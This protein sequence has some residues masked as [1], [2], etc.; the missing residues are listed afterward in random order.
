MVTLKGDR[1]PAITRFGDNSLFP[2]FGLPGTLRDQSVWFRSPC[3]SVDVS[4]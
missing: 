4:S 2:L 3:P 1:I